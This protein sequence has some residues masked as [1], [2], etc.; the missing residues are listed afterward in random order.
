MIELLAEA[1]IVSFTMGG[2][3]GAIIA[4]NLKSKERATEG[5]TEDSL[6]P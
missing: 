1:I 4:L 3:A 5:E 2:L 6:Q